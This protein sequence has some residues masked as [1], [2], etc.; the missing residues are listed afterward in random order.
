MFCQNCGAQIDEG[1][2]ICQNCGSNINEVNNNSS[3]Y[4]QSTTS[5]SDSN[6]AYKILSYF[7]ILWLVGLLS[8][9][10]KD[11]KSVRF[12]VGQG[13]IITIVY[14]I[15]EVVVQLMNNLVIANI[16]KEKVWG[17]TIGVSPTG[18]ALMSFLNFAVVIV[19]SIFELIGIINVCKGQDKELPII[20]EHAFYK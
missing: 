16:F 20:G 7:G 12:H 8:S 18:L 11:D 9:K 6:K 13:M 10:V 1:N 19:Y 17:V 4:T 5:S 15:V 14:A 3:S 2:S